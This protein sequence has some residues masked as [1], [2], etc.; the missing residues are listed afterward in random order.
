MP[1]VYKNDTGSAIT[2]GTATYA[3]GS[4]GFHPGDGNVTAVYR[5]TAPTTG[6]YSYNASFFAQDTQPTSS[7]V[8][9][10]VNG[11]QSGLLCIAAATSR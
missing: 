4:L 5:F 11:A 7:Q 9:V 3:A 1:A 10:L 2:A 8:G 6:L